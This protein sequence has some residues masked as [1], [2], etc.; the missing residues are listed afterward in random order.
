LISFVV[1]ASVFVSKSVV[2]VMIPGI[3]STSAKENL[4]IQTV[5][6]TA[7][8]PRSLGGYLT[9]IGT[10]TNLLVDGGTRAL[11]LSR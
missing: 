5:D 3:R 7:F 9:L 2:V 6:P 1:A 4:G 8:T 11:N 10:S